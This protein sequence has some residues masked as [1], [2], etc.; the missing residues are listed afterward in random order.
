MEQ[1]GKSRRV[2]GGEVLL[3]FRPFFRPYHRLILLWFL[4]YGA[5][6]VLGIGAPLAVEYYFDHVLKAG[7]DSRELR[8]WA[9][10]GLYG[11]YA[12]GFHCFYLLGFR[13]TAM[14]IERVVADLRFTVYEK[15]HRLSIRFFDKNVSGEIVNHVLNDTRQLLNLVGGE[16]V[17]VVLQ[18]GNGI[19]CVAILLHWNM[20]LGLV[21]LVFLPAYGLLFFRFLP[22]VRLSAKRWRIAE[23]R[24][25]GNWGEKLRGMDVVQA[26]AREGHEGLKHYRFGHASS[27]SWYRMT[28]AGSSMS[29]LGGL[30]AQVSQHMA[31]A[32]GCLLVLNGE[33]NLGELI[34][35]SALI[36]YILAPVQ[37][38]FNV[39]NTWQQ[40]TVS[41][42]RIQRLL[43]EVE[44]VLKSEGTLP[45]PKLKGWV[46]FEHVSF[47][48]EQGRPVLRDVTFSIR[49]GERV[50]LVGH[51]GS[52]KTSVISLLQGFYRPQEGSV[53][54]DGTPLNQ[55]RM[56]DLR[57][58]VGV[59][60]QDVL[61]FN[62]TLRG[63]VAYGKPD[64]DDA[65]I[66]QVLRAVQIEELVLRL[67]R[68]LDTMVGGEDGFSP[69]AGE[70][71]RLAIARALLKE[72]GIVVL[73]E[74][75]SSLDSQE[76]G[77]LQGA[78]LGL[79]DGRSAVII[80]HRLSTIRMCDTVIVMEA[81]RIVEQGPPAALLEDPDSRYARLHR[82]HFRSVQAHG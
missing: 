77:R 42:E 48:Y 61:L 57:N 62:D 7:A 65:R 19:I 75:S 31:Y 35:L 28:M 39:V 13:G 56:Q 5:Y 78:I 49:P 3:A 11:L 69:S 23:D 82:S 51:T 50:A 45:M 40:S 66:M 80:A 38:V 59:V 72:P 58:Q 14:V 27:D 63:N 33:L 44:E 15:L 10:V 71:Q 67:P 68:G 9:F 16:L 73:D 54:L 32:L 47:A 81:G 26:F 55:I 30:V 18:I 64:A 4:V 79:L 52:G 74:A 24:L 70:A 6:F 76:E 8:L 41:A 46:R 2:S 1:Q 25:W 34:S 29:V 22:R 53:L 21:V 37:S 12:L 60:S 36:G 20:R 17:Q 43:G